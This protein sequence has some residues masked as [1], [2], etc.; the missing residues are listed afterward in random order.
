M[1]ARIVNAAAHVFAEM[2]YA[3][4]TTNAIALEAGVSIGSLYSYFPD[5][6]AILAELVQRHIDDG[7][8]E[9]SSR[10]AQPGPPAAT[11]AGRT[12]PFVEAT[13][14]VHLDNPSLHRVIFE[15]AP[16]SPEVLTAL[17]DFERDTVHAVELLLAE[18]PD[19]RVTD[20]PLAAYMT[21]TTIESVTHRYISSHPEDIDATA[22]ID[23]ITLM[24]VRYLESDGRLS[25]GN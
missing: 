22:L 13:V 12:R 3:A 23:Q 16:R 24:V 5:K 1:V 9:I 18:D 4:G 11:L 19:V 17:R 14:V 10:L 20:I 6:D 7:I 25:P 2:G 21:V 8:R 15:E